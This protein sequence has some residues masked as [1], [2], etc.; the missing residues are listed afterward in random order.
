MII[1]K[2]IVKLICYKIKTRN[3]NHLKTYIDNKNKK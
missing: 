1:I 3:K 2:Y